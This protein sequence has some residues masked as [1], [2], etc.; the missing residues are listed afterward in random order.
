MVQRLYPKTLGTRKLPQNLKIG[1][2]LQKNKALADYWIC[3]FPEAGGEIVFCSKAFGTYF[4]SQ[5]ACFVWFASVIDCAIY[6]NIANDYFQEVFQKS[7]P[8]LYVTYPIVCVMTIFHYFGLD[9]IVRVNGILFL[10]AVLPMLFYVVLGMADPKP[11]VQK[12]HR[13][14]V[15][16]TRRWNRL[17]P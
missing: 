8:S 10:I 15:L 7:F 12:C 17:S 14:K 16:S 11:E 9:C 1:N 13:S 6:A 3:I 2:S 5:D 4:G